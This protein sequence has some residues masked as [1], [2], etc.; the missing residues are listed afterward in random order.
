M[1]VAPYHKSPLIAVRLS[2][3]WLMVVELRV[4]RQTSTVDKRD[5]RVGR[6][7]RVEKP[8]VTTHFTA[9]VSLN[10]VPAIFISNAGLPHHRL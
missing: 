2:A 5:S 7:C 1:I 3:A 6:Y 10:S 4:V 9:L 8:R